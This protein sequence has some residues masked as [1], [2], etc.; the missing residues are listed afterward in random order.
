MQR[1]ASLEVVGE[2][3]VAHG[4][5][6]IVASAWALR[7]VG[8]LDRDMDAVAGLLVLVSNRVEGLVAE[9]NVRAAV[10]ALVRVAALTA[11]LAHVAGIVHGAR[12]GNLHDDTAIFRAAVPTAVVLAGDLEALT[13][14]GER[15]RWA[16]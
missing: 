2:R 15:T 6:A 7:K 4:H 3:G 11:L 12:V 9:V 1:K 8:G 5:K 13:A 14:H 16:S 10:G